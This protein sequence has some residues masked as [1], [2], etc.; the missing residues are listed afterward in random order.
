M[1]VI[2]PPE[3]EIDGK[4][5]TWN[6]AKR[7]YE[8][9]A[10]LTA[11]KTKSK[12]KKNIGKV[13]LGIATLKP[14][15]LV[16]LIEAIEGKGSDRL[17]RS[18]ED[19][20]DEE[21]ALSLGFILAFS[22]A[23][24]VGSR[25]AGKSPSL[26][27]IKGSPQF[28]KTFPKVG[29]ELDEAILTQKYIYDSSSRQ[30]RLKMAEQATEY[31]Q[32]RL[33]EEQR[34]AGEKGDMA[35]FNR[36]QEEI[37]K[38]IGSDV[39][40]EL[41]EIERERAVRVKERE[42]ANRE[43]VITSLQEETGNNLTDEEWGDLY[44]MRFQKNP[45]KEEFYNFKKTEL[46]KQS[47]S[48]ES[49]QS[50]VDAWYERYGT[51]E[52]GVDVD[53]QELGRRVM[54]DLDPDGNGEITMPQPMYFYRNYSG[55]EREA[56]IDAIKEKSI[57]ENWKNN[58]K[59]GVAGTAVTAVGVKELVETPTDEVEL[60]KE[61]EDEDEEMDLVEDIDDAIEEEL[62]EIEKE[63]DDVMGKPEESISKSDATGTF[64]LEV[65][66]IN[67]N[68]LLDRTLDLSTKV[69]NKEF[70]NVGDDF[71]L[72][73]DYSIPVLFHKI[74]DTLYV[75]FRG[76]DSLENLM[77]DL[78]LQGKSFSDEDN[79]LI[80]YPLAKRILRPD[81]LTMKF[82]A[83][84]L[85]ALFTEESSA[86]P[87]MNIG[88][89][90]LYLGVRN[91]IKK[92]REVAKIV[93]TGHS[94]GGAIATMFGFF[95]K[96][97]VKDMAVKHKIKIQ[98]VSYGSPRFVKAQDAKRFNQHL[99]D[100]IRVFNKNDVVTFIPL[101]KGWE[102]RPLPYIEG[103]LHTGKPLCLDALF[104]SNSINQFATQIL[105]SEEP[106]KIALR[107]LPTNISSLLIKYSLS[108]KY[109]GLMLSCVFENLR[110]REV[111]EKY[112]LE[113]IYG[114]QAV[115]Q[116]KI[117]EALG[118][119]DK[120][121]C[122][123]GLGVE[124]ILDAFDFGEDETQVNFGLSTLYGFIMG[125]NK[126]CREAHKLKAYRENLDKELRKEVEEKRDILQGK[127]SRPKSTL[128]EINETLIEEE[129]KKKII[130]KSLN[131][132]GFCELREGGLI[133]EI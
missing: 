70:I 119:A 2:S 23:P 108:E 19:M 93:F 55:M 52:A 111:K 133:V 104:I 46:E 54:A 63:I 45:T 88:K 113:N 132:I 30:T 53:L 60:S 20:S 73:N 57:W 36:I 74:Q 91:I 17:Y 92:Y 21:I 12:P 83:G 6:Y 112:S 115:N 59:K 5:Y 126:I 31:N 98:V 94:L 128:E 37:N 117:R 13:A 4:Y 71:F 29:N 49:P 35:E 99:P 18:V 90:P 66:S 56:I 41:R 69:Y 95:Y 48:G 96:N 76:T 64:D 14:E 89:E 120:V 77:T 67:Y 87:Y 44:A 61:N 26:K 65:E 7:A 105:K 101:F 39:K 79:L 24:A 27:E 97:E 103:F 25:L 78:T 86:I 28:K 123:D 80:T 129:I 11:S 62:D 47:L 121:K 10:F 127:Q 9:D 85:K 114:S 125:T 16:G 68:D 34:I 106:L 43:D 32:A 72:I 102:G 8:Y 82:H 40:A 38:D 22:L 107:D 118:I 1:V 50:V 131:V 124:D 122:L 130:N 15:T 33:R 84:F 42:N 100:N 109:L 58:Y 51:N 3:Q 75:A 116:V 110:K 81:I